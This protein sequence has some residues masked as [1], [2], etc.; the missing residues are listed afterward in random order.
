MN[1]LGI[2]GS[3]R[4]NSYNSLLL[5]NVI[6]I[7]PEGV[8]LTTLTI[9]TITNYNEDMELDKPDAITQFISAIEDADA[10]LFATPEYNHSIPGVLKNALD[11][12]SRPAFVSPLANKPCGILSASQNNVGGGRA[13]T[14]LKKILA[15]TLSPVYPSVEY[16]LDNAQKKF[17]EE[18]RL[19][20]EAAL[21]RLSRYVTGF[22]DWSRKQ[23]S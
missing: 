14:E 4:R 17:D 9:D 13:Q 12:A 16:L 21:R 7:L 10:L 19:I 6:T 20:D 15:S 3:L 8:R 11:W 23:T 2:S 22:V 1:I 18:G 5:Q